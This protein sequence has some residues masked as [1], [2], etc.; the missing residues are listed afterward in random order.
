MPL[1]HMNGMGVTLCALEA[2]EDAHEPNRPREREVDQGSA[3]AAGGHYVRL[4]FVQRA[5][6]VGGDDECG[7]ATLAGRATEFVSE[8]THHVLGTT[9]TR[10]TGEDR[11]LLWRGFGHHVRI[12]AVFGRDFPNH[13]RPGARSTAAGRDLAVAWI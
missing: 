2:R 4:C 1:V 6:G 13:E 7:G 8:R 5:V 9:A 10:K 12:V 3:D 11:D